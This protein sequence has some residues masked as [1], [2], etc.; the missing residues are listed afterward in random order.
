MV[1]SPDPVGTRWS[2]TAELWLDPSGDEARRS[3][4]TITLTADGLEYTW[5]F[6]GVG[7]RLTSR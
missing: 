6:E 1:F 3:D 4:C 5:A 7:L 2:G